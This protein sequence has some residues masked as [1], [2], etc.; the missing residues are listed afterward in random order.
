MSPAPQRQFYQQ[1]EADVDGL[2]GTGLIRALSP[3]HGQSLGRPRETGVEPA[4]PM[5]AEGEAFV[6][7]HNVVPLRPLRLVDGERVAIVELVGFAP[8]REQVVS[9]HLHD[10]HGEKDEHL[11]PYEGS[12]DWGAA[13]P[14]LKSAPA[15]NLPVVLELKEKFGPEAPAA[16]EQ[17][18]AARVAFDRFE[19]AWG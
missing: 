17:L 19:E 3:H 8:L 4:G 16:P 10:N 6:E 11:L 12:I 14:L 13:I 18:A 7:Q 9:L 15:D 1:G 2:S 5:L